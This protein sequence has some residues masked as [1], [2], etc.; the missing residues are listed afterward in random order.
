MEL[1]SAYATCINGNCDLHIEEKRNQVC[2]Y[3]IAGGN[4]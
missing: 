2:H 1:T 4:A 3:F